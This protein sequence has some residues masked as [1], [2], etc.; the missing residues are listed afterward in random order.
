LQFRHD[1]L[2]GETAWPWRHVWSEAAAGAFADQGVHLLDLARWLK[3]DTPSVTAAFG[4]CLR[5]ERKTTHGKTV[6]AETEDFGQATLSFNDD[7]LASIFVSRSASG[8]REISAT[9]TGDRGTAR[10]LVNTD[11]S[12]YKIHVD[13]STAVTLPDFRSENPYRLWLDADAT[14]FGRCASLVDGAIAQEL[15]DSIIENLRNEV[16]S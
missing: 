13:A 16:G 7:T 1:F 4:R 14:S 5:N 8:C 12:I 2:A 3:Q 15:L 6:V 11:N 10:L 9:L